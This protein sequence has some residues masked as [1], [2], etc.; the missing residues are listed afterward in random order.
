MILPDI[1][2]I[3]KDTSE[4]PELVYSIRSVVK[5]FSG[6]RIVFVGGQPDG[7]VPD[8]RIKLPQDKDKWNSARENILT[9][10]RD[11]R[12]SE[13]I[14]IFNDDFFVMKKLHILPTYSNGKLEK[15]IPMVEGTKGE[16]EFTKRIRETC[17]A[18]RKANLGTKNYE[19]HTPML[20]NRK[21]ML[22]IAEIFPD[23]A[24][25]RTLYGNYY[26]IKSVEIDITGNMQDGVQQSTRYGINQNR[27][28]VSTTD[29][30]FESIAGEELKKIFNNPSKYERK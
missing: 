22:E 25:L 16:T 11:N 26:K 28:L 23:I 6:H 30:S 2:Y 24:G 4:N 9:A 8:L 7:L 1:V 3:L 5:N 19:V 14:Y 12:L 18:L 21:K 29:E 27:L 20:V 10:C 13:S 15:F 17:E